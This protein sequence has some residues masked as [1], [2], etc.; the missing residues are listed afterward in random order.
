MVPIET[1]LVVLFVSIGW[2]VVAGVFLQKGLARLANR[3]NPFDAYSDKELAELRDRTSRLAKWRLE[4]Q[5]FNARQ[6]LEYLQ[7]IDRE[8]E[9]RKN[10]LS[11][12]KKAERG[13][14][15]EFDLVYEAVLHDIESKEKK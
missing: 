15:E 4:H 2:S 12:T 7:K 14:I 11:I 6:P 13:S 8:I 5:F 1:F 9:R 3:V 10:Q